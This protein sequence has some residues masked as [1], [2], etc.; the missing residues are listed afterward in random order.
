MSNFIFAIEGLDGCGKETQSKLISE[1]LTE[2]GIKNKV[3][4]FPNYDSE[5]GKYITSFL[6]GEFI[7][8][9]A[10]VF[11][12]Y[13][14]DRYFSYIK[15]WKND[16]EEGTVIICDRYV[17]SNIIYQCSHLYDLD[18]F[19]LLRDNILH[20]EHEIL[21]LPRPTATYFLKTQNLD[22]LANNMLKRYVG[23][24]DKKDIYEKDMKLLSDCMYAANRLEK[25]EHNFYCL[26][27]ATQTEMYDREY[28]RNNILASILTFIA[29][30]E[31]SNYDESKLETL[32][33][34]RDEIARHCSEKWWN[35]Y[36]GR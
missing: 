17:Y 36:A 26:D 7:L 35:D 2:L 27:C 15:N 14:L 22:I 10:G 12:L 8:P 1:S 16:Y 34:H 11:P 21:T 32:F 23:Q 24:E 18:D 19:E 30:D 9:K 29:T 20:Y 5:T 3:V 6:H 33:L 31:D 28:I 4:S 25:S 13:S